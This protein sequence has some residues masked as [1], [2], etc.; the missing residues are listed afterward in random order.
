MEARSNGDAH[1]PQRA[2]QGEVPGASATGV[3]SP[4]E[5]LEALSLLALWGSQELEPRQAWSPANTIPHGS[6]SV[7]SGSRTVSQ[8]GTSSSDNESPAQKVCQSSH[9]FF[10]TRT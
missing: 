1:R 7:L 4:V 5:N 10:S 8:S 3:S 6:D 2:G 9:E